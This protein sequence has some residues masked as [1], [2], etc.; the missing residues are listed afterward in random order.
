MINNENTHIYTLA[1]R[2]AG[3]SKEDGPEWP[4][5]AHLLLL[6]FRNWANLAAAIAAEFESNGKGQ[7]GLAV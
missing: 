5:R 7:T 2:I 3:L 4:K 1:L 6:L